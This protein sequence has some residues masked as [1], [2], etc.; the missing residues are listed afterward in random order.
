MIEN[1]AVST[2]IENEPEIDSMPNGSLFMIAEPD[3]MSVLKVFPYVIFLI[4]EVDV[5]ACAAS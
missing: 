3:L 1:V 4:N 5:C 2:V